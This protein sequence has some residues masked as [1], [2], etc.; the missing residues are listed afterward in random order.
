MYTLYFADGGWSWV[1]PLVYVMAVVVR[2]ARFNVE[3]GGEAKRH[4]HGL[5]SPT[6]GMILAERVERGQDHP[7]RRRGK[8]VKVPLGLSP[9]ARH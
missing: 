9:L 3:Q 2:L 6:P 1:L 7:G 5:P 4:F 8:P